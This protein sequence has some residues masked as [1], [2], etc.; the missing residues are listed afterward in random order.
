MK[1]LN[2]VDVDSR[3]GYRSFELWQGD[4]TQSDFSIDLLMISSVGDDFYPV[5]G[6]VIGSLFHQLGISVQQLQKTREID[7]VQALK[8]WVSPATNSHTI[9]R[10]LCV[11]IPPGG[12]GADRIVEQSFLAFLILEAREMPLSTVC[13]PVLGTGAHGLDAE[14]L[15]PPV[16][17]GAQQALRTVRS[18]NRICFVEIDSGHAMALSRAMDSALGRVSVT[19]AKGDMADLLRKEIG[20]DL[21][22]IE[23]IDPGTTKLV[24]ELRQAI[25]EGRSATIGIGGRHLAE[26]V[27]AATLRSAAS[28][29]T[30]RP[31]DRC[32]CSNRSGTLDDRLPRSA[33]RLRK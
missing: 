7:L 9:S 27:C 29:K 26:Y 25:F 20:Y 6:T 11:Q 22:Q 23:T 16:L 33:S 31:T 8:L 30:S 18:I 12:E 17:N 10:L 21:E 2:V 3:W 5:H 15:V 13:L 19:L 24:S 14:Q 1:R 4:I 28:K 32:A